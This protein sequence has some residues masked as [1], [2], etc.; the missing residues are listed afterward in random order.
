[1]NNL[2]VKLLLAINRCFPLSPNLREIHQAK[3]SIGEYQ[4]WE[5]QEL[6]KIASGF[7]DY[8]N[9]EG[10]DGLDR[11]CGLGGKTVAYAQLVALGFSGIDRRIHILHDALEPASERK[12]LAGARDLAF[13]KDADKFT[14]ADRLCC[15]LK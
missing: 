11:G 8:W 15:G 5:R 7:G 4:E 6:E 12:Q 14:S 1:M 3:G 13:S 2:A 10:K 9:L